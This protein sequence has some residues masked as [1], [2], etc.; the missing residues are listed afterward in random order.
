LLVARK[1]LSLIAQ[2]FPPTLGQSE[3][4]GLYHDDLHLNNILVSEKGEITAVLDW[5]CVS[6]L[7]LWMLTKVPKF[8]DGPIR[9]E[10]PQ[11]DMYA[12]MTPEETAAAASRKRDDSNYLDNEGKNE[13]YFIHK[14]EYEATQLRKVFKAR[15]REL[16]PEW[17]HEE[18]HV[19][20][21]FFQAITLCDGMWVNKVRRWADR[22]E[23]GEIVRLED[24]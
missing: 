2:E 8:L 20:V 24:V 4:T 14:M 10:E 3:K 6:A 5:E 1:L 22:I 21:T 9:E 17:R 19:K 13:L 12:D 18:S 15:L 7:P 16:W 11:R 23:K